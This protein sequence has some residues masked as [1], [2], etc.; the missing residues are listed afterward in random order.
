MIDP[1]EF[2]FADKVRAVGQDKDLTL[3]VEEKKVIFGVRRYIE[4]KGTC[5]SMC[6]KAFFRMVGVHTNSNLDTMV[7]KFYNGRILMVDAS[8]YYST[9]QDVDIYGVGNLI[10]TTRSGMEYNF[11]EI[12]SENIPQRIKDRFAVKNNYYVYVCKYG[13]SIVYVGKGTGDRLNHCTSGRSSNPK[14]NE[15]AYGTEVKLTVEKVADK[16]T[17]EMAAALEESYM[18][19]LILSGH[20]LCNKSLPKEVRD[21]LREVTGITEEFVF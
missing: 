1:V 5:V 2:L 14:L 12:R 15:L 21:Y 20:K 9:S 6:K 17:A 7:E 8:I 16:L 4:L 13:E 18:K 10:L 3:S 11:P 19:A